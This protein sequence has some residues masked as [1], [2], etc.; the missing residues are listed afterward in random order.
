MKIGFFDSGLG[1]L[2]VL[3]AV[4]QHLPEYDYEYYGDTANLPYGSKDEEEI[5]L[6]TK[7]GVEEL[8]KKN[9]ALVIVACNTASAESLRRLQKEYETEGNTTKKVLGVIIPTIEE[10]CANQVDSVLLIG[11]E[12][13]INSGKY[14]KEFSKLCEGLKLTTLATPSLVPLIEAGE[15]EALHLELKNIL[16]KHSDKTAIILGCTHYSLL[17]G[18]VREGGF[19]VFAQDEIIPAKLE[20]YL[21]RHPEIKNKL[22]LGRTRNIYLTKHSSR[23]D[24]L[25]RELLQGTFITEE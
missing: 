21:T 11:T 5:F 14:E 12:R 13:T 24:Q 22:T 17:K 10:V 23:Y 7:Y 20:N 4:A 18:L 6:L 2:L 25:I 19:K 3:K 15:S 9:C 8:F 1:G 16:S